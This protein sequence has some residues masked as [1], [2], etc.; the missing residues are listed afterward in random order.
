MI[1]KLFVILNCLVLILSATGCWSRDEPKNLAMVNS[2]L[3]DLDDQGESLVT[4]EIINTSNQG[5]GGSG[6]GGSDKF[7]ALIIEGKGHYA[8]D[9]II[10]NNNNLEKVIFA[11]LN[12]VR[13]FSEKAALSGIHKT[14]DYITRDLLTDETPFM[15]VVPGEDPK[16]IYSC[17]TGLTD[18]MGN[19]IEKM[20]NTQPQKS[21]E[22]VFVRTL[23]FMKDFYLDGKEPVAGLALVLESDTKVSDFFESGAQINLDAQT[24]KSLSSSDQGS[25]KQSGTQGGP[26]TSTSKSSSNR[27]AAQSSPSP[28]QNA[29]GQGKQNPSDQENTDQ[30]IYHVSYE[31]LA[32]FKGDKLVGYM[33]GN[34]ARAYNLLTNQFGSSVVI[35]PAGNSTSVF[36]VS[37]GKTNIKTEISPEGQAVFHVTIK[38]S[39]LIRQINDASLDI[40]KSSV[41]QVLE[42]AVDKQLET[43]VTNAIHKAQ[44]QFG[45]DIFGFG[46]HFHAQHPKEFHQIKDD[47]N[48]YFSAAKITVKVDSTITREGKTRHPFA[49]EDTI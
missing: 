42:Q 6:G 40:R 45:S 12:K 7:S 49:M 35:A 24:K 9:A 25:S 16:K 32:A 5:G 3:Y 11:G 37:G 21:N 33:N 34:E 47:W 10:R 2:A 13:F 1:K 8:S 38:P 18:M 19:Y 41:I 15:V 4:I 31:G 17:N 27:D 30:K 23:E 46:L 39:V 44:K 36:A 43:E 29:S 26:S 48:R 22:S 14:M 20:Y 28:S